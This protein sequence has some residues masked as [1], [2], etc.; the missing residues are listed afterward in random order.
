MLQ[1][2]VTGFHTLFA[3]R[4]EQ[5][6]LIRSHGIHPFLFFSRFSAVPA[7]RLVMAYELPVLLVLLQCCG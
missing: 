7:F 2:A 4:K 1:I 6:A 5:H 3:V